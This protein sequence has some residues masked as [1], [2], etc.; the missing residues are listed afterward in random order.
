M[1]N[2]QGYHS[3]DASPENPTQ[4]QERLGYMNAVPGANRFIDARILRVLIA[5]VCGEIE[6]DEV[7]RSLAEIWRT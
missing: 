1:H 3:L 4:K 5:I 2:N 7:Y 6:E